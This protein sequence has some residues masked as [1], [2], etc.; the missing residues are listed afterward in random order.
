MCLRL[1]DFVHG[2]VAIFLLALSAGACMLGG[3]LFQDRIHS[4]CYTFF[5][6]LEDIEFELIYLDL[7]G[8]ETP[9]GAC[10]VGDSDPPFEDRIH[11][12]RYI[13]SYII[14]KTWVLNRFI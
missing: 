11:S 3:P 14:W 13:L 10:M 12:R 2:V 7:P 6:N 4:R 9:L 1:M 5:Y 8:Q